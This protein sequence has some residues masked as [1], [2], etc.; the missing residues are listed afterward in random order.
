MFWVMCT[1]A[2]SGDL[3]TCRQRK[4]YYAAAAALLV[5]SSLALHRDL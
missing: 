1:V 3:G 4:I 2:L 5:W